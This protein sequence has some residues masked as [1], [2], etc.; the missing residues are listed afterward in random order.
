MPLLS[1]PRPLRAGFIDPCLPTTARVPPSGAGWLHEIKHDGYR[2]IARLEGR[3][4]RL[5]S[6]RDHDW[7]ERFRRHRHIPVAYEPTKGVNCGK[8]GSIL[9]EGMRHHSGGR[10]DTTV[11]WA[12]KGYRVERGSVHHMALRG[13]RGLVRLWLL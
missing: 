8:M 2:L 7:T 13:T 6:R 5:F 11:M 10:L 1:H 12:C 4:T 3:G 9:F